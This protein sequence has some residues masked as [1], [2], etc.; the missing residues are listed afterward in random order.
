MPY[1]KVMN[2]SKPIRLYTMLCSLLITISSCTREQEQTPVVQGIEHIIIIGV[3]GMSPD[4]IRNSDSPNMHHLIDIGVSTMHG[5][6]VLPTTSSPNWASMLMGVGPEQHGI[7]SNS[8]ERDDFVLPPVQVGTEQLFPT[9]FS[10]IRGNRPTAETGVIYQWDGFARL[11]EKSAVSYSADATDEQDATDEA[12]SYI[13]EKKP[14]LTFVQLDHVDGAGH[15]YGHGSA[16]YYAAVNRADELIGQI[17]DAVKR[18]G[19]YNETVFIVTADHGGIGKGHGGETLAEVE[20]PFII[21]GKDIKKNRELKTSFVQ[22]DNAATVAFA[23]NLPIPSAWTGRPAKSAFE[24]FD[25]EGI[26]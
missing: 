11:F 3:D 2:Q 5:R 16:Q 7:T 20:I 19:I 12:V 6:A 26:E 24:G 18:A 8:W 23:L 25:D 4:G 10:L 14:L 17:I 22:Y 9:V 1:P 21:S 15:Q 13:R